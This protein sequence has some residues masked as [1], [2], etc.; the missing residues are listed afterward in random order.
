MLKISGPSNADPIKIYYQQ[1][2]AQDDNYPGADEESMTGAWVGKGAESLGLIGKV[3]HDTFEKLADGI[4][5]DG[6]QLIR[7]SPGKNRSEHRSAW[8]CT[9]SAGK[10]VSIVAL[11]EGGDRGLIDDHHAACEVAFGVLEEYAQ[12]RA[13]ADR[14][15]IHHTKNLV[16]A[17]FTHLENRRLDPQ[18]HSHHV[19]FNLTYDDQALSRN[20]EVPGGWRALQTRGMMQAQELATSVYRAELAHRIQARGYDIYLDC[21]GA[22]QLTGVPEA[23]LLACS[24]RRA[25]IEVEAAARMAKARADGRTLT[26]RER[27]RIQEMAT[28]HT[29]VAKQ[30]NIS[31]MEL[32]A[33]WKLRYEPFGFD[34]AAYVSQTRHKANENKFSSLNQNRQEMVK[35]VVSHAFDHL[36]ERESVVFQKD[37]EKHA[38]QNYAFAGQVRLSDIRNELEHRVRA[39]ELLCQPN[40]E[41]SEMVYTTREL[42]QLELDTIH[43]IQQGMRRSQAITSRLGELASAKTMADDQG[44]VLNLDQQRVFEYLGTS[45]DQF[46]SLHGKAGVGK[47][48]V[49]K[50]LADLAERNGYL[51]R[52]FAPT[53]SATETLR[54][55]GLLNP[56]TVQ[57]HIRSQSEPPTHQPQIWL[58][59]EASLIGLRDMHALLTK[60]K[61]ERARVI[62]SGD[63]RQFSSVPAGRSYDQLL[64]HGLPNVELNR[65]TRQVEARQ[66][67]RDAVEALSEGKIRQ[68]LEKLRGIEDD[69]GNASIMIEPDQHHRHKRIADLY[70]SLSGENLVICPTNRERNAVNRAIREARIEK[71]EVEKNGFVAAVYINQNVTGAARKEARSYNLGNVIRFAKVRHEGLEARQWYTVVG[72][73]LTQNTITVADQVGHEIT[74]HPSKHYGIEDIFRV[75]SREFSAG[76]RIQFRGTD[77]DRGLRSGDLAQIVAI[78]QRGR[79]VLAT[80]TDQTRV[81]DFSEY[82]TVD[83]AYVSTGHGAQGRTVDNVIQLADGEHR[84]SVANTKAQYVAGTRERKGLYIV[85][86]DYD[87]MVRQ[88][89]R[90]YEKMVALD[91][92]PPLVAVPNKS[93]NPAQAPLPNA[94]KQEFSP[95]ERQELMVKAW[96]ERQIEVEFGLPHDGSNQSFQI[97][98]GAAWKN[99]QP[100]CW[101]EVTTVM[102]H[103]ETSHQQVIQPASP[104][105]RQ[106]R[107]PHYGFSV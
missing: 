57:K 74:Y 4:S 50:R 55:S 92:T 23:L 62:L 54:I 33:G 67:I 70:L 18:L 15:Q 87:A 41:K 98:F 68:G 22:V 89:E 10:S 82:H 95:E 91:L 34:V 44:R 31:P 51:V 79:A 107:T 32:R 97:I 73:N 77:R 2:Y 60:A 65:I 8:D 56:E 61:S 13:G 63:T 39:G 106:E 12:A 84:E 5:P 69:R 52:A 9:F 100:A 80:K 58:V 25:E 96:E 46:V 103:R 93:H 83:Y 36:M 43:L 104:T 7:H 24:T 26:D 72:R 1:E 49:L 76:D 45:D 11:A 38:L 30:K 78:D 99:N 20:G 102:N 14:N 85:T 19:V 101:E 27:G 21:H 88:A 53:L 48:L 40:N 47:S 29:R 42:Q 28:L 75:E 6:K 81:V 86:D 71:G 17:R 37:I 66:E 105:E 94:R 3:N 16:A 64:R 59:D 90:Q 35:E